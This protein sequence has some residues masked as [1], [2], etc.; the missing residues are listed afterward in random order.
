MTKNHPVSPINHPLGLAEGTLAPG[1]RVGGAGYILKRML[2][3]GSLSEVWLAWDRKLE[4]EVA[5]KF[6]PQSEFSSGP[7]S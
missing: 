2:G 5:L 3:R 7:V 4:H 6:L 1:V